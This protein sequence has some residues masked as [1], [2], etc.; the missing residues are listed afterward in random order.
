MSEGEIIQDFLGV[1]SENL[2]RPDRELVGLENNRND[3]AA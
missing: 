1:S 2:D 3:K